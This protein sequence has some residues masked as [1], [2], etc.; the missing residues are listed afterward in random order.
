MPRY[1]LLGAIAMTA[2][3][4]NTFAPLMAPTVST[5]AVALREGNYTLDP[6]HAALLF[7]VGHLGFS[8]FV[9]RFERFDVS[10]HFDEQA[11]ETARVDAAIDMT[12]LDVA[13][14]EFA[15]TL[16]GPKWFDAERFPE[17]SFQS[18][19]IDI[20]GDNEGVLT[21]DL[22]MHGVT[23]PVTM[24][25]VFNGGGFDRLRGAYVIGLS[26]TTKVSRSDFGVTRFPVL[27]SDTVELEI[28]AEFLKRD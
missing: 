17:T 15:A 24:D 10:L 16:M 19:S 22:T 21:G 4:A 1:L 23:Q 12:S 11:P 18:T 13:N 8:K 25:I 28:E 20:T 7:K 6:D 26:G 14:D 9:G 5:E 3:C 2:A 27:V